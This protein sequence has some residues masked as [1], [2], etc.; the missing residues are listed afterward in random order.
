MFEN[1]MAG[2]T[3]ALAKSVLPLLRTNYGYPCGSCLLYEGGRIAR[4]VPRTVPIAYSFLSVFIEMTLTMSSLN[5]MPK[6]ANLP[7][8]PKSPS[9][10]PFEVPPRTQDSQ[11]L[12]STVQTSRAAGNQSWTGVNQARPV[13]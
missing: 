13:P 9:S 10:H 1:W 11:G 6:V 5:P 12:W 4:L 2:T 3:E 7:P 8:A